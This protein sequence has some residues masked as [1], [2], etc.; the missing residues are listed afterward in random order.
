MAPPNRPPV[1]RSSAARPP[2]TSRSDTV[3]EAEAPEISVSTRRRVARRATKEEVK[4]SKGPLLAAVLLVLCVA[5]AAA[6]KVTQKPPPPPVDPSVDSRNGLLI[7]F[8]EGKILVRQG[9]WDEAKAKFSEVLQQQ[10]DFNGG[11]VQTYLAACE[12]EIPNQRA[13][14]EAAA[15][16]EHGEVAK[17]HR[18]LGALTPDTQQVTRRDE[19]QLKLAALFKQRL[20]EGGALAQSAGELAKM[21]KL[22]S[23][24]E[25]LLVM[26]PE[27]RDALELKASADR[28]LRPKTEHVVELLKDDPGLNVQR[29]FV[30]GDTGAAMAAAAACAAEAESCRSLEAKLSE[31]NGLLKRLESLQGPELDAAVRLERAISGGK[32][33]PQGKPLATRLGAVN[34]PKASAARAK[35]EWPL[36]MSYALKVIEVD[37]GHTGAAA[38]VSEGKEKARE[39]FL[40]CY[41]LKETNPEEAVPLCNDVVRMLPAGDS[42][43]QKAEKVLEA[44]RAK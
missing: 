28:A 39:L 31:L 34:Y 27:D 33:T 29:L 4:K 2:A 36:A 32:P 6:W 44:L 20:L 41:Q 40:R 37:P 38:I 43:R 1:R 26:R 10:P 30:H 35:G 14:E 8:Q 19:L 18:A 7:L 25:D 24:A 9:K 23:L 13:L 17:A 5:G 21:K 22:K 11:T 16:I 12:K 15:A 42:Q 3:P